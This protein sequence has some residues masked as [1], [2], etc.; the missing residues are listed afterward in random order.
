ME[1]T[2][3]NA[4]ALWEWKGEQEWAERSMIIN[5]SKQIAK[6]SNK[7]SSN[8]HR[9]NLAMLKKLSILVSNQ[10]DKVEY[11]QTVKQIKEQA[12]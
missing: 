7:L 12:K 10:I 5:Q 6:V 1:I 9:Y 2:K 4:R 8:K 11:L 3:E